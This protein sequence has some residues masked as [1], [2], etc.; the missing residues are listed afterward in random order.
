MILILILKTDVDDDEG[1]DDYNDDDDD[2]SDSNDDNN[3]DCTRS[4]AH[5]ASVYMLSSYIC[6]L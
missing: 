2:D 4:L 6:A 1:D 5:Y 3:D